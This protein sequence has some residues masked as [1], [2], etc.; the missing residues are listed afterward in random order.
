MNERQRKTLEDRVATAYSKNWGDKAEEE[1]EKVMTNI[2]H[3]MER[4]NLVGW[5]RD[6]LVGHERDNLV[7]CERDNLIGHVR[8]TIW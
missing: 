7:G 3:C 4:D 1:L 8:G 6:N 2:D 5:E